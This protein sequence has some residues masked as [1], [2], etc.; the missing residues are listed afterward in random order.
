MNGL[1]ETLRGFFATLALVARATVSNVAGHWALAFFSLLAAG[2]IW[3]IIQDIENPRVEGIVPS[4]ADS[5][6]IPIEVVNLSP[7]FVVA[8]TPRVRVRVEARE[9]DIDRLG[10]G[11]FQA[12]VDLQGIEQPGV[13]PSLPVEVQAFDDSVTVLAVEPA[14]VSVEVS[15]VEEAEFPVQVNIT[16]QLP[17]GYQQVEAPDIDP[18]FVTVIG[19]PELVANVDRVEIDVNLSGR[20]ENFETTGELVARNRNGDRQTVTL[21]TARATVSFTIEQVFAERLIPV[22]ARLSGN[23]A[24]GYRVSSI[25]VQPTAVLVTGPR[26]IVDE[27]TELTLDVVDLGGAT[28]P[29]TQTRNI[30]PPPNV[31][32]GRESVRVDVGIE[33]IQCGGEQGADQCGEVA[34]YAAVEFVDIPSGLAV[35]PGAYVARVVLSGPLTGLAALEPGDLSAVASLDGLSAGS[36]SVEPTVDVDSPL[37]V[38]GIDAVAVTLVSSQAP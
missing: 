18:A 9:A 25:D 24:P 17:A 36:H 14:T 8:D 5:Q 19:R 33:P 4:E 38:E 29:I 28:S 6:G 23:P 12:T 21:S 1:G 11:D 31:S 20:R 34:F 30:Q 10:P 26:D 7:D 15:R 13:T 37:R 16:G 22:R 35:S 3:I 32:L 27:L 2:A